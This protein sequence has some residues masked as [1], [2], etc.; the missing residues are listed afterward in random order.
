MDYGSPEEV[1]QKGLDFL[2]DEATEDSYGFVWTWLNDCPSEEYWRPPD[3]DDT[4]RA[5]VVIEK[6]QH[7]GFVIPGRFLD[8]DY[9]RYLSDLLDEESGVRTYHSR[10]MGV[11][12]EVNVN[13]LYGL[14]HIDGHR[15]IKREI[16]TYLERVLFSDYLESSFPEK[17]KYYSSPCFLLYVTSKISR[18]D[19]TIFSREVND[20]IIDLAKK[21]HPENILEHVWKQTV[22]EEPHLREGDI[23]E[24]I[25]VF[26]SR[27]IS[28][29]YGSPTFTAAMCLEAQRVRE[30]S[31]DNTS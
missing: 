14:S 11:C 17:T 10:P 28:E 18:L 9:D 21:K 22:L 26:H 15:E 16:G 6:A 2:L 27:G 12:P 23:F 5:R 3:T 8:F 20:R 4:M 7:K 1:I 13:A 25:S 19:S 29:Q 24:N 31:Y 30:E